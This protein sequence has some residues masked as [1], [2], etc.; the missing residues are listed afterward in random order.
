MPGIFVFQNGE[1]L[2]QKSLR[3]VVAPHHVSQAAG[4]YK[5]TLR[6]TARTDDALAAV[7]FHLVGI[8]VKVPLYAVHYQGLRDVSGN[9]PV[10]IPFLLQVPVI[11]DSAFIREVKGTLDIAFN[12]ALV[13]RECEK[14]FVEPLDMFPRFDG[15]VL[16]HVLREGQHQRLAAVQHIDFLPLRLRKLVSLSGGEDRYQC[17]HSQEYHPEQPELPERCLDVF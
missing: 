7:G 1:A 2:H 11:S 8:I 16:L 9:Q 10:E 15:T 4:S 5:R 13:G 14:E 6:D 17:A 12:G 3:I